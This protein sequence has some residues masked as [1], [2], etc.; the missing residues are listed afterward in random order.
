MTH[1]STI[2]LLSKPIAAP[3]P[4]SPASSKNLKTQASK[5]NKPVP[6]VEVNIATTASYVTDSVKLVSKQSELIQL[7]QRPEGIALSELMKLTNWQAHSIRGW[8]S[9]VLRKKLDLVVTRFKSDTGETCYRID[10]AA[11]AIE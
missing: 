7:M 10:A 4:S 9:A 8:I 11:V 5:L 6:A 2:K 1:L 3:I